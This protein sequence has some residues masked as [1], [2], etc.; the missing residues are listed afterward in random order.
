MDWSF[1]LLYR[2]TEDV[3]EDLRMDMKLT[4][5]KF[6]AKS[7][8]QRVQVVE[9][10]PFGTTLVLDGKTQSAAGDE[11]V[12]CPVRASITVNDAAPISLSRQPVHV[13]GS[14]C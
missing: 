9:T 8:F 12:P 2:F 13:L 10:V 4:N 7:P 3:T 5:I 11:K 1:G 14:R 6:D